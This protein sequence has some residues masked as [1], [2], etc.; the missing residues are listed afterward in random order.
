METKGVSSGLKTRVSDVELSLL[1]A[2]S[3]SQNYKVCLFKKVLYPY[4][5]ENHAFI[6]CLSSLM[7][8]TQSL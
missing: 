5:E 4:H 7:R 8:I 2:I 6:C 3:S 1:I